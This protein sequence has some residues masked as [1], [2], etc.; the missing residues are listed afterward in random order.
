[1]HC[2]N[3]QRSIESQKSFPILIHDHIEYVVDLPEVIQFAFF[4]VVQ[5]RGLSLASACCWLLSSCTSLQRL[6]GV[7]SQPDGEVRLQ[8]G[9][10]DLVEL[11]NGFRRD[12]AQRTLISQTAVRKAIQDHDFASLQCRTDAASDQFSTG[13]LEGQEFSQR[14]FETAKLDHRAQFLTGLGAAWFP[15]A[16]HCKVPGG[17]YFTQE[18]HLCALADTVKTLEADQSALQPSEFTRSAVC[19]VMSRQIER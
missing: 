11:A 17:Q 19:P 13:G 18:F 15:E 12:L 3:V 2:L 16:L 7:K 8:A 14:R 10:R 6:P 4:Y 9:C 5:I 1:M